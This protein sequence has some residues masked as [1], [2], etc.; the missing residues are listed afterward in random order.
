MISAFHTR[1]PSHVIR[2]AAFNRL[3]PPGADYTTWIEAQW[4][5]FARRNGYRNGRRST[6]AH[7]H[8]DRYLEQMKP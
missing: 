5:Q 4:A 8:F 2:R 3:A 1:P 7:Q 6:S